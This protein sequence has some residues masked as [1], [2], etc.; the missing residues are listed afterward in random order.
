[1]VKIKKRKQG[2]TEPESNW[3]QARY[4]WTHQLLARFGRLERRPDIGPVESKFDQQL[5]GKLDLHQVVWWD[6]THRKCVIGSIQNTNKT[7]EILFPRNKEGNFELEGGE[8]TKER[9]TRLNVKY[10]KECRL[11]LGVAMVTPRSDDGTPLPSIGKRCFPYDYTS[12]VMISMDDYKR[13]MK[14]EYNRVRSLKGS[15]GY[16]LESFRDPNILYYQND[17]VNKLKGVGKKT[18]ERLECIGMKT[19][20][21]L[22]S[23]KSPTDINELPQK[24]SVAQLTKFWTEAKQAVDKDAPVGIDHRLSSNPYE[25]KFGAE[26]EKHLKASATF[27]HSAY[28]CDYIDHMMTESEKIMKGTIHENT[29]MVYHDA[30][31]LMTSKSTKDWMAEKGYLKRWI[32]PSENLY[33]HLPSAVAKSYKGK[34]IGNSPEYMPLDTHL[35]QDIHASHD[36]H[37]VLTHDAP[38]D[39]IKKF[40]GSTPKRLTSSYIR[41]TH[42]ETGVVPISNRIMEDINRVLLSMERVRQARGC[43]IDE[44]CRNGRRHEKNEEVTTISNNWGGKRNKNT[45]QSYLLHL[46]KKDTCIHKDAHLIMEEMRRSNNAVTGDNDTDAMTLLDVT[47]VE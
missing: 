1:M 37:V 22:K 6:E 23:L 20:G 34:P 21:D 38:D 9:K 5:Q 33:D 17:P 4:A 30:L 13:L 41:L 3:A 25:S 7:F 8:Y 11:G 44:N 32:L 40:S 15:N 18:A 12:K 27:S 19:V 2:S 16:W 24:M 28:I 43:L 31:A 26:W 45:Q 10:E 42:P 36:H 47:E 39:N 29:W 46:N 14:V 35:N